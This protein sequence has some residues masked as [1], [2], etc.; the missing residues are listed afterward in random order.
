M[1]KLL[2]ALTLVAGLFVGSTMSAGAE[3]ANPQDVVAAA[4]GH[5]VQHEAS[6]VAAADGICTAW[7]AIQG[8]HV[9][10]R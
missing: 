6:G 1:R 7:Y 8:D 9:R 10:P 2:I 5:E 3:G 4:P